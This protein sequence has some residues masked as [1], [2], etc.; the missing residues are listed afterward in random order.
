M[1]LNVQ[2]MKKVPLPDILAR[3]AQDQQTRGLKPLPLEFDLLLQ[4]IKSGGHSGGFLAD[5]FLSAYRTDKPFN[6]SLGELVRLD[7][8]GFRLFHEILHIRHIKNWND[9]VLY[10]TEQKVLA[11]VEVA[12]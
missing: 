12:A 11:M 2:P 5:A 6:H 3:Q 10:D 8:E 1:K 7:S 9:A 4:R